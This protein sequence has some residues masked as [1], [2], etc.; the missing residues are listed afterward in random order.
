MTGELTTANQDLSQTS[1]EL[2]Q[3]EQAL[4]V[5]TGERDLSQLQLTQANADLNERRQILAT[6]TGPGR[7]WVQSLPVSE[8]A[9]KLSEYMPSRGGR[10]ATT[11]AAGGILGSMMRRR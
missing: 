6:M 8:L 9:G 7:V 2:S 10:G 1:E 11:F 5:V 4:T 3:K